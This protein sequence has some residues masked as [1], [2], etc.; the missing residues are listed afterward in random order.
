MNRQKKD[1]QKTDR[2][3]KYTQK[4]HRQKKDQQKTD[5]KR[6]N[7]QKTEDRPKEGRQTLLKNKANPLYTFFIFPL[8]DYF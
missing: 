6:I 8:S 2:Q 3:I 1:K 5:L 7:R 4:T